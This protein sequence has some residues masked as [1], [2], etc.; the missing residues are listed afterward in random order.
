MKKI[1]IIIATIAL[2]ALWGQKEIPVGGNDNGETS[3][4]R[5]SGHQALT[6]DPEMIQEIRAVKASMEKIR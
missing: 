2:T 6:I 4:E 3:D 5:L 1:I